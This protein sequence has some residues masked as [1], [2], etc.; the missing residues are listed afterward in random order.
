[1]VSFWGVLCVSLAFMVFAWGTNY[2]LSLYTAGHNTSPVKLC[3]RGS[4]A[5]ESAVDHAAGARAATQRQLRIPALSSLNEIAAVD[6]S[7]RRSTDSIGDVSP[8][9]QA[10]SL[11]LRPPPG[12][13]RFLD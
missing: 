1:L 6:S 11:Y 5:A 2:K 10:P 4:D 12:K 9:R 3:T 7:D 13:R 8:L